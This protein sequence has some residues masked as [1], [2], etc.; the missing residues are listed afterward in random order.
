MKMVMPTIEQR[1]EFSPWGH[2]LDQKEIAPGIIRVSTTCH[3][4]IWISP[5]RFAVMPAE[6][7]ATETWCGEPRWY[8]EHYD[9][10]VVAIAFPDAFNAEDYRRALRICEETDYL[11][12]LATPERK[13]RLRRQ[14]E[15][16]PNEIPE[17]DSAG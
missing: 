7:R 5:E 16:G 12:H 1:L 6:C 14:R 15:E 10:A 9:W 17:I 4:G 13:A 11:R 3:G 2:V 8:E